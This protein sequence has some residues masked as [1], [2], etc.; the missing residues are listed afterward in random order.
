[1]SGFDSIKDLVEREVD[2]GASTF[3]SWRKQAAV[4]TTIGV[5]FD[6]SMSAGNPKPNY[7]ASS[8]L[9]AARL[10]QSTDGGLFHGAAVSP[11]TKHLRTLMALTVTAGAVPLPMTL[12]DYL[13]YYPFVDEG[14][15][16]EEQVMDNTAT[17]SRYADGAGVRIMPVVVAAHVGSATTITCRYTNQD[18]TADRVTQV[19]TI[20]T[21]TV[22]GTILTSNRASA[23]RFGPF[24]PLQSGDTGVRSIEGCTVS[25]AGDVGLFTLVLVRPLAD[26]SLRGIDAPVEVDFLRDRPSMPRIVDDAYLN[27]ICYPSGSLS[28]AGIHGTIQTTWS[29]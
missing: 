21:Q 12:C 22:N 23:G 26:I 14:T 9:V 5:W 19:A 20:G 3:S 28:A 7:Y 18:G 2:A 16:D 6:L 11:G 1:M 29:T 4:V 24:L 17:L 13:L 15:V 10:A 25:G 8:P 27:F